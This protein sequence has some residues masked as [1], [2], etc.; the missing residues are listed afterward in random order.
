MKNL[1]IVVLAI[2]I[3]AFFIV[4]VAAMELGVDKLSIKG[5]EEVKLFAH[6]W[7]TDNDNKRNRIES[8]LSF[9]MDY[10]FTDNISLKVSPEVYCDN[11][12][13]SKGVIDS[14]YERNKLRYVG[15]IEEAYLLYSG[16]Q[17]D[18]SI[19]KRI[20]TW[21]KAD[22]YK[23][24]DNLNSCEFTDVPD[25]RKLGVVSASFN[26]AWP[27]TSVNFVLVPLFTPSRLPEDNN[28]WSGEGDALI[29]G[30]QFNF[31]YTPAQ[32]N[33][34]L[35]STGSSLSGDDISTVEERE[36][37]PKQVRNMQYGI[38]LNTTRAGW[39]FSLSYYDGFN[40]V[41]VVRERETA[42]KIHFI[43][44][45]NKMKE[46]GGAFSTTYGQL[47]VHG[48]G[49]WH[50][51]DG[52]A[53]DDYLEYIF[54]GGYTWDSSQ[55]PWFEDTRLLLEYAGQKVTNYKSNE[56]Y[57]SYAGYTRPLRNDLYG[58]LMIK[59]NGS[60][61]FDLSGVYSFNDADQFFQPKYTHKFNDNWKMA[62]GLDWFTG[63]PD[64]FFGKWDRNDRFFTVVT[65]S[66]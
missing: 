66:F 51:T 48:E 15:S 55:I 63:D 29:A 8:K 41:A 62:A 45:F 23:P 17:Y 32:L 11:D 43:P 42:T 34:Y 16:E 37:P 65:Y 20:Y 24:L 64:D 46:I 12:D 19:G 27:E 36:L 7:K 54:G 31:N 60:N 30:D 6:K 35:S 26:Y 18:F 44:C 5:K 58:R 40:N 47:E 50:F 39:D 21:G 25:L 56:D 3:S 59:I 49:A 1:V 22:G 38:R 14:L 53:D 13:L 2:F 9:D 28:R 61:Q 4:D 33:S 10:D 57:I 52:Q